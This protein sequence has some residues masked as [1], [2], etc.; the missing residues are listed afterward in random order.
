MNIAGA[1]LHSILWWTPASRRILA[2]N[3]Y[4]LFS[5]SA[6][7]CC[8]VLFVGVGM[9]RGQDRDERREES[10]IFGR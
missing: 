5:K 1:V 3:D 2:L 7:S 9:V 8:V 10:N 4:G 6:L